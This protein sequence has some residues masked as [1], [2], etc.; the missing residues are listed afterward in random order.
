[1]GIGGSGLWNEDEKAMVVEVF[2]VNVFD[3]LVTSLVSNENLLMAIG[4]RSRNIK[5]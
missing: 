1:V 3:C 2:G 5:Q 4:N